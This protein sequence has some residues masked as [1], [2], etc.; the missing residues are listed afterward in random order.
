MLP[1]R[2]VTPAYFVKKA[3]FKGILPF[4]L[5][6]LF[7]IFMLPSLKI[8]TTPYLEPPAGDR[9]FR[10]IESMKKGFSPARFIMLAAD[11]EN[12]FSKEEIQKVHDLT[13]RL[14][15]LD[16]IGSLVSITTLKDIEADSNTIRFT[17]LSEG[18]IGETEIRK[19]EDTVRGTPLFRKFFLSRDGKAWS[20]LV[21][22]QNP[23]SRISLSAGILEILEDDRFGNVRAFG[24]PVLSFYTKYS[25]LKDFFLLTSL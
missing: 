1:L 21:F 22:P 16:G 17:S 19:I 10:K 11:T 18:G 15:E 8:D 5:V 13:A 2:R 3:G 9:Y 6:T 7:S 24:Y 23:E 25:T 12:P 14:S 20:V 4:V